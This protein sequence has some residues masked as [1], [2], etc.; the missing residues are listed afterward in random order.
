MYT[1][2]KELRPT[3]LLEGSVMR[4]MRSS[5]NTSSDFLEKADGKFSHYMHGS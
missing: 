5:T 3:L 2:F 1:E 4:I